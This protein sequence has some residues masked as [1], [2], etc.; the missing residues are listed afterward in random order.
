MIMM[1]PIEVKIVLER[2]ENHGYEAYLVGGAVRSILL[3]DVIKDYDVTTSADPNAISLIFQDYTQFKIGQKHGT[4]VVLIDKTKI[5]ITPYRTEKDYLDHRHPNY[6]EFTDSLIEDLKRR[7]FTINALCMDKNENITDLFDGINDIK[8]KTIKAIG[9]PNARFNED[10]L[11]ILRAL[12]FKAKLGFDIEENTKNALINNSQ[13][14]LKISRE[15]IKDEILGLLDYRSAYNT[16]KEYS[17]VFDKFIQYDI[18]DRDND[19]SNSFYAL[20]YLIRNKDNNLK[21]LKFSSKEIDLLEH[22]IKATH[23]NINSD[24]EFICSLSNAYTKDV[25]RFLEQLHH[26]DLS[27]AY[28]EL[29]GYIV[30][31]NDLDISGNEIME[32]GYS[33]K[34]IS[35]VKNKLLEQIH[36]KKLQNINAELKDWIM[37][38]EYN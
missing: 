21:E 23:I 13:L 11:R 27:S 28:N 18:P 8:N 19:F 12:R 22:L 26:L 15:R 29:K 37:K 1:L 31:L 4:V 14:L 25:L 38:K 3:N 10:A 34:Q 7:D 16:I 2:L 17:G 35:E 6:V 20:A 24:Y 36:R 30:T 32:F 9:N 5:D 33:G